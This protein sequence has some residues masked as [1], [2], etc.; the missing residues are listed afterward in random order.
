MSV[1]VAVA[2]T[3]EREPRGFQLGRDSATYSAV[4]EESI[5]AAKVVL[6]QEC[7]DIRHSD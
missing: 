1:L 7:S 5:V 2:A 4:A 3:G 6:G